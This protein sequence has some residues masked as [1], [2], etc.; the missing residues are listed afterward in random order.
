MLRML[1]I[2]PVLLVSASTFCIFP[3]YSWVLPGAPCLS[4]QACLHFCLTSYL[5]GWIAC[6]L[7]VDDFW[8]SA[9]FLGPLFPL[10]P[11]PMGLF[12]ADPWRG[13]SL[14][15]TPEVWFYFLLGPFLS[16]FWTSSSHDH[17][18]RCCLNPSYPQ[19][20]FPHWWTWGPVHLLFPLLLVSRNCVRTMLGLC[21]PVLFLQQVLR[22]WKS[23]LRLFLTVWSR[24]HA[25]VLPGHHLYCSTCYNVN[26]NPLILT[27]KLSAGPYP[28]P[29]RAPWTPAALKQMA[30]PPSFSS[31]T[32]F[33]SLIIIIREYLVSTVFCLVWQNSEHNE[34]VF[35]VIG[36]I[37]GLNW[38][39]V[40][41]QVWKQ[42]TKKVKIM[43]PDVNHGYFL[44]LVVISCFRYA[45]S[46]L[47]VKQK[48]CGS[49]KQVP[50]QILF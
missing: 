5:L 43:F 49:C 14:F 40:A 17:C 13:Q 48:Y 29:G 6:E 11:F 25:F 45:W 15:W 36:N 4:R 42:E 47:T 1:Y 30:A 31:Q 38:M 33:A 23:P 7:G 12:Q 44:Y 37:L 18:N 3:F 21:P 19:W 9:S 46:I 2:S 50:L 20:G 8:M 10:G 39:L 16:A 27:C 22:W 35:I 34:K 24:P 41:S 32:F 26:H 28:C